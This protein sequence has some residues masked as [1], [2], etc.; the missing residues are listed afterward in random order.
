MP[1][2]RADL[3]SCS[4]LSVLS[5]RRILRFFFVQ[6]RPELCQRQR[7]RTV[8]EQHLRH[9]GRPGPPGGSEASRQWATPGH[10]WKLR[11]QL[12]C[13][14][15]GRICGVDSEEQFLLHAE[16]ER[17]V[18]LWCQRGRGSCE[19][20]RCGGRL[21]STPP[22][23]RRPIDLHGSHCAGDVSMQ[24]DCILGGPVTPGTR[25]TCR[26]MFESKNV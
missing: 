8:A 13:Q 21:N 16:R 7:K 12:Q 24:N 14:P 26:K 11:L 15:H 4:W 19:W 10:H 6:R 2:L 17:L 23:H 25:K 20:H 5:S 22:A 18:T 1:Q 3:F 9:H